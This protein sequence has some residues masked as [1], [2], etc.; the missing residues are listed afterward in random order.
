MTPGSLPAAEANA[1]WFN[2]FL[3][4]YNF[5]FGGGPWVNSW[6][7]IGHP[8]GWDNAIMDNGS[9]LRE[10]VRHGL[11]V[12]GVLAPGATRRSLP[13]PTSR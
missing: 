12:D 3:Q 8:S 6:Q 11:H 1:T 10:I 5:G 7:F 2:T 13:L 9:L 4:S